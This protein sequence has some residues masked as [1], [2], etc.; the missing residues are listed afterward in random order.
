MGQYGA[1]GRNREGGRRR[2]V[3]GLATTDKRPIARAFGTT[4]TLGRDRNVT[5]RG[6]LHQRYKRSNTGPTLTES[7]T[8]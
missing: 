4:T 1:S 3:S 6:I 2:R 5:N 7:P 8:P